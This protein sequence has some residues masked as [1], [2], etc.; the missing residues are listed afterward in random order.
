LSE[1]TRE[2]RIQSEVDKLIDRGNER[3]RAE[4]ASGKLNDVKVRPAKRRPTNII[5]ILDRNRA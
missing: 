5:D 4:R 1:P 3:G 2:E